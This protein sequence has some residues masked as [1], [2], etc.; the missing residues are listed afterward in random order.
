MV[1]SRFDGGGD[2][3]EAGLRSG[4]DEVEGGDLFV[5][6]WVGAGDVAE[7]EVG[8][9]VACPAGATNFEATNLAPVPGNLQPS[10]GI[11]FDARGI[12]QIDS[13]IY[14]TKT[15]THPTQ[16]VGCVWLLGGERLAHRLRA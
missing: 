5:G 7:L 15:Q 4:G 14:E 12:I 16:C 8:G 6:V 2:D 11:T 10:N 3:E 13:G 9:A 1:V